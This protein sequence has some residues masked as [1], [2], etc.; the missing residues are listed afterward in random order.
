[1]NLRQ[2]QS[3]YSWIVIEF[4]D[5]ERGQLT[6]HDTD[7]D[8]NIC[9]TQFEHGSLLPAATLVSPDAQCF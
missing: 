1:M 5:R 3:K 7:I 9:H 2:W 4:S 8:A 6:G